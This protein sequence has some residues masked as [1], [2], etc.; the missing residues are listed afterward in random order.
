MHFTAVLNFVRK[1]QS[2]FIGWRGCVC[3]INQQDV[4][5]QWAQMYLLAA[6]LQAKHFGVKPTPTDNE[7]YL[8]MVEHSLRS[9]FT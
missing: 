9:T 3:L 6:H 7:P 5:F 2:I 8:H 4:F 1:N